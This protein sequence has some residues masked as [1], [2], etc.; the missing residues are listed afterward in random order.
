MFQQMK[1]RIKNEKGLTLIEL[2]AVIVI[3]AIVAA[4][5]VPAIGNIIDNSRAKALKSD[6]INVMNAA[7]IYFT[8]SPKDKDGADIKSVEIQTLLDEKYLESK[9]KLNSATVKYEV[10]GN[11]I[12][13]TGKSGSVSISVTNATLQAIND[14]PDK[15]KDGVLTIGSEKKE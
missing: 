15:P 10:G 14:G 7:N 11:T 13:A 6:V 5:A 8:D 4:I 3:L 12:T 9:G 2:L 1:K